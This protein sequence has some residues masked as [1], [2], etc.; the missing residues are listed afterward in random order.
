MDEILRS[1]AEFATGLSY[2]ELPNNVQIAAKE[3][4]ID[5]LGCALGAIDCE[6]ARIGLA[7]AGPAAS[8]RA[9]GRVIGSRTEVAADAAA[10]VNSCMVRYLDFNDTFPGGHPSDMSGALFAAAPVLGVSG[11]ELIT[12]AVIGYEVFFRHIEAANPSLKG[13]D[14]GTA[15]GMGAAAALSRI[16]GLSP[17]Q[18][19][20]AVSITTVGNMQLRAT[21]SGQLS[22]W[23][24]AATAY[25]VRNAVFS[26][27]LAAQGMTGPDG[28]FLA[29]DGLADHYPKPFVWQPFG[30]TSDKFYM[31]RANLKF[32]PVSY[33]MQAAAW[34][35]IELGKQVKAENLVSIAVEG[36][37]FA[38][39]ES[40]GEP[41]KW[42]PKTKGTADHSLPYI[43]GWCLKH[44]RIDASAFV[45][46]AYLDPAMRPL[47]NL[48]TVEVG[49]EME[50]VFP[51]Q[52][53]MR[54]TATDKTGR[55][56]VADIRNPI[57]HK[58]NPMTMKD[59]KE[60]FSRLVAPRLRDDKVTRALRVWE[61]IEGEGSTCAA[62]DALV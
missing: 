57:G 35:G 7:L 47:L 53:H 15:I 10:F 23:K 30:N 6:T 45:P 55:K 22:M 49:E 50:Q 27:H 37:A 13:F 11:K 8:Q 14:Q 51:A 28:P 4:L 34:A 20:H 41:E 61:N 56:Y 58:M 5:S 38:K 1:I 54:A 29:R 48:I 43:L 33:Q 40:G 24:G 62:F 19:A 21:R 9:A 60:K 3:R 16:L 36:N 12:A 26:V 25:A 32:W 59:I 44:G 42:D 31:P 39:F 46:E 2:N 52:V 17:V 18:T